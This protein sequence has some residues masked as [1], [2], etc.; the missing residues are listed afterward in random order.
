MIGLLLPQEEGLGITQGLTRPCAQVTAS[1]NATDIAPGLS[2]GLTGVLPDVHSAK[3]K[4]F[5]E[6]T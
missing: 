6:R 4:R 5:A 3:V 2:A 1:V